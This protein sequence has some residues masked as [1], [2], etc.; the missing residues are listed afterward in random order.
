[1]ARS[2]VMDSAVKVS[3]AMHKEAARREVIRSA[4][5]PRAAAQA[6]IVAPM[7]RLLRC[8][9]LTI[10]ARRDVV[11]IVE[12]LRAVRVLGHMVI[13]AMPA[14]AR[15][16]AVVRPAT[17]P[18]AAQMVARFPLDSRSASLHR[19]LQC[20][21]VPAESLVAATVVIKKPVA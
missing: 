8:E 5:R 15:K 18:T 14:L 12:V 11:P 16:T 17:L 4:T 19:Q 9:P 6:A 3:A 13:V 10:V 1:M 2:A 21:I 7:A 20:C